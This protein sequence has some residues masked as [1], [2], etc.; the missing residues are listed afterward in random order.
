MKTTTVRELRN[1]YARVLKW[2]AAGQEIQV[3]RRG[4]VVAKVIPPGETSRRVDWSRS[5]ALRV[6]SRDKSLSSR[7]SERLLKEAQGNW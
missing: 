1:N 2:V 3:T 4:K 7:Q 6:T 5:S